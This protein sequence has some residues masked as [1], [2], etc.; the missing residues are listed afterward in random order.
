MQELV[1][2]LTALDPEA[3]ES[4]KVVSY[5]DALVSGGVGI[6]ALLRGA[7]V[8]SGTV[9]GADTAGRRLRVNPEGERV[10]GAGGGRDW[11]SRPTPDGT[12]WIERSGTAHANDAMVLERLALAVSLAQE[13]RGSTP[14]SAL[15]VAIDAARSGDERRVALARLRVEP[16]ATVRVLAV[17]AADALAPPSTVVATPHGLV[18]AAFLSGIA[19]SLPGARAGIGV[20]VPAEDAPRSFDTAVVALRLSRAEE[21]VVDASDYGVLLAAA[22]ALQA[23]SHPDAAVLSALDERACE[24]LHAVV[25]SDSLRGAASAL[26]MHHSTVQARYEALVRELG[27]DPRSPKGRARYEIAALVRRLADGPGD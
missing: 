12:V 17:P 15:H 8:L 19:A 11:P 24:V 27:W 9:A 25:E 18:R 16:G 1:G 3:S 6:E 5:F 21:A 14:E 4:L 2:R 13:R 10:D 22:Q 20:P 7:A 23:T 26:G